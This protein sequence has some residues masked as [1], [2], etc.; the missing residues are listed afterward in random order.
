MIYHTYFDNTNITTTTTT[1]TLLH[2]QV[3][4]SYAQYEAKTDME[5]A[6]G[7]FRRGY[8]LLRRQGLKEERW[9]FVLCFVVLCCCAVLCFVVPRE[10]RRERMGFR[11]FSVPFFCGS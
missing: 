5:T 4:I 1:T 9:V 10:S 2:T 6:R 7:V 8:D 11:L 3:W